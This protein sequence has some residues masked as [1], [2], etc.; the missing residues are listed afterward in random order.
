VSIKGISGGIKMGHG[1]CAASDG[2][3]PADIDLRYALG[4]GDSGINA[5]CIF[6]PDITLQYANLFPDDVVFIVRESRPD[7][8]WLF[9]HVFH[10]TDPDA[11]VQPFSGVT[12]SG[13]ETSYTIRFDL[14]KALQGKAWLRLAICGT[15]IRSIDVSVNGKPAGTVSLSFWRR[16]YIAPSDSGVM[17]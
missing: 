17:V 15:G 10:N 7:R 12:G 6:E 8:D 16:R 4:S 11:R 13:R 2:D 1:P 14:D 9:A 5:Y 3:F